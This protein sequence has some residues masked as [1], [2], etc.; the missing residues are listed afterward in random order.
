MNKSKKRNKII[1]AT[2]VV[3][4]SLSVDYDPS[5]DNFIFNEADTATVKSRI[6]YTRA[7]G[8]EKVLTVSPGHD[9]AAS[10]DQ[11]RNL[12]HSVDY[13]CAIDTNTRM[14]NNVKVS[15]SVIYQVPGILRR[16]AQ[17]IPLIYLCSYL[18]T[19]VKEGVNPEVIG[20]HLFLNNKIQFDHFKNQ[21][22]LGLVV[23]SE[24]AKLDAIN[25]ITV[26]YYKDCFLPKFVTLI[27][28]STDS[29]KENI[30]NQLLS[31][32]D[33]GAGM[34][35]EHIQRN[36]LTIPNLENGNEDFSGFCEIRNKSH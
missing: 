12:K 21:R 10:F 13:L 36:Q 9:K 24:L 27:Y 3:T 33:K 15:V 29:G 7:S 23:D 11:T 2:T 28:A 14:I 4:D 1:T 20:W 6:T 8:K 18:I 25:S 19:G 30:A 16:H 32:C 34:V 5:T 26:P 17:A 22:R 31:Y 35:L